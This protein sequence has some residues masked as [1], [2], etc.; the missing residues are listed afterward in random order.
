M[1]II[2]LQHFVVFISIYFFLFKSKPRKCA[3]CGDNEAQLRTQLQLL[4]AQQQSIDELTG[5]NGHLRVQCREHETK[6][7]KEEVMRK[8]WERKCRDLED[9]IQQLEQQHNKQ[10]VSAVNKT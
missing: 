4:D 7:A 1:T 6:W 9:D 2:K 5:E 10:Q 8:N 3:K